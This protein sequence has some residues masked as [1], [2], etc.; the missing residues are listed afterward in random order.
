MIYVVGIGPGSREMMTGEAIDILNRCDCI[1]GYTAYI[2]LL[3]SAGLA[4]GKTLIASPMTQE[5]DR[6]RAAVAAAES[7]ASVAVVSSGDAGVYGMASLV[8]ET[9][10]ALAPAQDI[11]IVPGVT[12]ALA[13]AAVL[14][15]PLA[16]DFAVISLSDLLTP[17]ALIEKRLDHAAAADFVIALYNPKSRNRPDHLSRACEMILRHRPGTTPCG[18]VKNIGR[19]GQAYELCTLSELPD[20][21]VDMFTTV[22]IGGAATRMIG[23]KLVTPR[24]YHAHI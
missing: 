22:I 24:G 17:W 9:V 11:Y 5:A 7:G 15:A 18:L 4:E 16:N 2:E 21:P 1:V 6:V 13:A 23:D 14:G 20:R 3:K 19:P 10:E 12:A 8:Y